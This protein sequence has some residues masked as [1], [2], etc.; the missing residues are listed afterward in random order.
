MRVASE[1]KPEKQIT[2]RSEPYTTGV[3]GEHCK[4]QEKIICLHF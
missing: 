4:A 2:E 1:E 3:S